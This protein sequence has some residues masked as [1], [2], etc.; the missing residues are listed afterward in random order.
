M[1]EHLEKVW[2]CLNSIDLTEGGDWEWKDKGFAIEQKGTAAKEAG[3]HMYLP[4]IIVRAVSAELH[5][6]MQDV[7]EKGEEVRRRQIKTTFIFFLLK[8]IAVFLQFAKLT[9]Q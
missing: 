3:P 5:Q 4:R 6:L 8:S 1:C 9:F 2:E 7:K